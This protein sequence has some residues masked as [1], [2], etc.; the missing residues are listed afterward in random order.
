M[1]TDLGLSPACLAFSVASP[2]LSLIA[3]KM[4]R[5]LSYR[6]VVGIRWDYVLEI[7][8]TVRGT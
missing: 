7:L 5:S 4:G 3:C 2:S 1:Q 8:I 6:D